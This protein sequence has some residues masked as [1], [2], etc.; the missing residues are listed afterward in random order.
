MLRFTQVCLTDGDCASY[1]NYY[2]RIQLF[3]WSTDKRLSKTWRSG[4]SYLLGPNYVL[5]D[6]LALS[7][8]LKHWYHCLYCS[9]EETRTKKNWL[10][11]QSFHISLVPE[12]ELQPNDTLH[13]D[14]FS[15]TVVQKC[16]EVS[17]AY[18][19]LSLIL[20]LCLEVFNVFSFTAENR[21]CFRGKTIP[22][23]LS[24]HFS[25]VF[26]SFIYFFLFSWKQ[27]WICKKWDAMIPPF[28]D[29]QYNTELK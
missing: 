4:D 1:R 6:L 3:S 8:I 7:T 10:I 12:H 13:K 28:T 25:E 27:Q 16:S 2:N 24:L 19:Y 9:R 14:W 17:L 22:E 21:Q 26:S 29:L 11:C 18:A 15:K 20:L 23:S 5:E